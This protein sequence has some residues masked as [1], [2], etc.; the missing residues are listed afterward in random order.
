M[1]NHILY[2]Y[3]LHDY[4][5]TR[6]M[7]QKDRSE[8]FLSILHEEVL[9]LFILLVTELPLPPSEDRTITL[10]RREVVHKLVNGPCTYSQLHEVYSIVPDHDKVPTSKLAEVIA[11]VAEARPG[12]GLEPSKMHLREECWSEY[13]PSFPHVTHMAH[14]HAFEFRPKIKQPEPMVKSPPSAHMLFSTVRPLLLSDRLLL[15]LIRDIFYSYAALR[16]PENK[17]YDIPRT[18]WALDCSDNLFS[19]ALHLL[20]LVVHDAVGEDGG[21]EEKRDVNEILE[22]KEGADVEG[23]GEANMEVSVGSGSASQHRK[24]A[25]ARFLLEILPS[26][27]PVRDTKAE[28]DS[29][30]IEEIIPPTLPALI[31]AMADIYDSCAAVQDTNN[32]LWLRWIIDRCRLLSPEVHVVVTDRLKQEEE[33]KRALE[34]ELRR[35]RAREKAMQA[36]NAVKVSAEAFAAKFN[37]FADSDESGDEGEGGGGGD[38]VSGKSAAGIEHEFPMCIVCHDPSAESRIGYIGFSQVRA[39]TTDNWDTTAIVLWSRTLRFSLHVHVLVRVTD[40]LVCDRPLDFTIL[41][42][43]INISPKDRKRN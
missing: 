16:F 2:R 24:D 26:P 30:V 28:D 3:G 40:M 17:S 19:R 41:V 7:S 38:R 43:H 21:G 13:D 37:N 23:K 10:L 4:V 6:G 29:G 11:A 12:V 18:K 35:K 32:K 5:I 42:R 9:V 15:Q 33:E 20:T 22:N 34:M 27:N 39:N 36:L 31:Y 8:S 14:Q 1:V 25:L